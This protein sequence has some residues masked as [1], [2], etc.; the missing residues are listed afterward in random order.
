MDAV[1]EDVEPAGVRTDGDWG[2]WLSRRGDN[3]KKF[4][5]KCCHATS[6]AAPMSSSSH[7]TCHSLSISTPVIISP[8]F[9]SAFARSS[10]YFLLV[11]VLLSYSS[12]NIKIIV[13]TG[14]DPGQLVLFQ[15]PDHLD[16]LSKKRRLFRLSPFSTICK[17]S[18]FGSEPFLPECPCVM[19]HWWLQFVT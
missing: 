15:D 7:P 11:P 13:L 5:S 14:R 10:D 4:W 17:K 16:L 2:E 12:R 19:W 1:R 8:W 9:L 6:S 18:C 3:W